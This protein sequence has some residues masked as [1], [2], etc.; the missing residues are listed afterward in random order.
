MNRGSGRCSRSFIVRRKNV[1]LRIILLRNAE[2]AV[3]WGDLMLEFSA[4][5]G[6]FQI[7]VS[8]PPPSRNQNIAAAP[9]P[10]RKQVLHW[11]V[12]L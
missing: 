1:D 7:R 9:F 10:Q 11:P 3:E 12:F 6:V 4:G 2:G 8:S 5:R